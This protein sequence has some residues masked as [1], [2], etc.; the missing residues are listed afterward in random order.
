M[1]LSQAVDAY[2]VSKYIPVTDS[3]HLTGVINHVNQ[4]SFRGQ[5]NLV[6]LLEVFNIIKECHRMCL[7]SSPPMVWL[8]GSVSRSG[9]EKTRTTNRDYARP[10]GLITAEWKVLCPRSMPCVHRYLTIYIYI[11]ICIIPTQDLTMEFA[12]A[13][14]VLCNTL[15][16]Y[17]KGFIIYMLEFDQLQE[18]IYV[19]TRLR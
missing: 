6:N 7:P 9:S 16:C 8:P 14:N 3:S 10:C 18:S 1:R 13:R 2:G 19:S 11:Y 15:C 4:L 12:R 5:N 17:Y